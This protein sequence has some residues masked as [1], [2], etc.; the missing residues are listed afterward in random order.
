MLLKMQSAI[1]GGRLLCTAL[2][3]YQ[4]KPLLLKL[5][6]P[7]NT[8]SLYHVS[9]GD[10]FQKKLI[11]LHQVFQCSE[12]A[13]EG[14]VFTNCNQAQSHIL[15][16]IRTN[17]PPLLSILQASQ[18][19]ALDCPLIFSPKHPLLPLVSKLQSHFLNPIMEKAKGHE[20]CF[21]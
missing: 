9:L 8:S 18:S 11:S 1:K 6:R 10:I 4:Q 3:M 7:S 17:R 19:T 12:N 14:K 2:R 13:W 5:K 15:K 20:R 21:L 16:S